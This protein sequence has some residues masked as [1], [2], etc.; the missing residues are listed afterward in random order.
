ME[1]LIL[2]I[3]QAQFKKKTVFLNK[4]ANDNQEYTNGLPSR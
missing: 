1:Y 4:P 2:Y 3:L